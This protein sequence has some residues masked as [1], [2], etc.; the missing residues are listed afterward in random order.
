MEWDFGTLLMIERN[1]TNSYTKRKFYKHSSINKNP[2][3]NTY[4][5]SLNQCCDLEFSL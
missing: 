3:C 5:A 2:K 4:M 1:R